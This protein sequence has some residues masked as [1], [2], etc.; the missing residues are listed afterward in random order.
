MINYN[1]NE[2]E[3]DKYH[4]HT[5]QIDIGLDMDKFILNIKRISMM[6]LLC[7]MEIQF[8]EKLSNTEDELKKSVA[9]DT[10]VYFIVS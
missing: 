7:I 1:E 6:M 8:M 10:S 3:I 9:F 2:N 5:I 4:I